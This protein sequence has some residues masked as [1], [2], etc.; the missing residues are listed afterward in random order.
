LDFGRLLA[1]LTK[2]PLLESAEYFELYDKDHF[3]IGIF[4]HQ[5]NYDEYKIEGGYQYIS[6]EFNLSS[7]YLLNRVSTK[8][9]RYVR[10]HNPVWIFEKDDSELDDFIKC[11]RK[12]A[13]VSQNH[14]DYAYA[15]EVKYKCPK[16]YYATDENNCEVL[17]KNAKRLPQ[18]G[19]E[20][21]DG[22]VYKDYFDGYEYMKGGCVK[23][24]DGTYFWDNEKNIWDCLSKNAK[25]LPEDIVCI[26][27][28]YEENDSSYCY[29]RY[30]CP[31]GYYATDEK[32]C[33]VLPKNAKRLPQTGFEC[34]DGFVYK[35]YF[36]GYVYMNGECVKKCDGIYTWDNIKNKW[37]CE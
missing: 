32:N 28:V 10:L 2:C 24:C 33:D 20:C 34:F 13:I 30:A 18:T 5:E 36:D 19:F 1:D 37:L 6:M 29:K 8:D 4:Y 21:F 15:C 9:I 14:P 31:K 3:Y 27:G 16:G 25:R 11:K 35:D 12:N 26:K 7:F 17:P 22:F 23:I